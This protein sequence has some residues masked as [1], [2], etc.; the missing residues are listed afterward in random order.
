MS[1]R[2][3][4]MEAD[5]PYS[6]SLGRVYSSGSFFF[7]VGVDKAADDDEK[8]NDD[9]DDRGDIVGPVKKNTED[10]TH[11]HFDGVAAEPRRGI[12]S[13]HVPR[14]KCIH[15]ALMLDSPHTLLSEDHLKK[16]FE[17]EGKLV[18]FTFLLSVLMNP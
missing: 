14:S 4:S 5:N 2:S 9:V 16:K 13:S 15:F 18:N 8:Y 17:Q 11:Q 12:R 3:S 1:T 7:G 10:Q 6:S